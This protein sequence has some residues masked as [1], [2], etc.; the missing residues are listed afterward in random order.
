[1][2]AN[3]FILDVFTDVPFGGNQLAVFPDAASIPEDKLQVIANE[4]NL[5]ETVFLYAPETETGDFKMRIFTPGQEMPT[6]GHPTIGTAH[7]LLNELY[8]PLKNTDVLILEQQVG[9]ISVTF[10]RESGHFSMLTMQQPNPIFGNLIQKR[11][12]IAE[13]L[14]ITEGELMSGMPIQCISCGN[15]FMYIPV[16][17]LDVLAKI[18]VRV[19]LLQRYANTIETQAL[20]VFTTATDSEADTRGRMFAPIWGVQEDPATGSASGPLG[21]YLVRHSLSDG[22]MITCEQGIE[23]GRPSTIKVQIG[24]ENEVVNKVLV[25]GEAVLVGKGS[26]Y[27]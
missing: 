20:Y 15:N 9:P 4:L 27:V 7:L 21:C 24:H 25:G 2:E 11:D 10:L 17:S 14:S 5:S 12:M 22:K 13:M 16:A 19:D 6:A 23:M 3:Y 8:K 18:K 26:L 1:M